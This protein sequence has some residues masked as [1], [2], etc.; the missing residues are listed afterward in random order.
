[1][2]LLSVIFLLAPLINNF[3]TV[4]ACP[5]RDAT[6]KAVYP[7]YIFAWFKSAPIAIKNYNDKVCPAKDAQIRAD[8]PF[9]S[10]ESIAIPYLSQNDFFMVFNLILNYYG[11]FTH[12]NGES[13]WTAIC[14]IFNLISSLNINLSAPNFNKY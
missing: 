11:N 9:A 5:D 7:F 13:P 12:I 4:I 2:W 1:M 8:E 6:C 14:S 3:L 10:T